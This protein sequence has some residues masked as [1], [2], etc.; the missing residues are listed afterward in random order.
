MIND[1]IRIVL[2]AVLGVGLVSYHLLTWCKV[3]F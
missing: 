3:L 1:D 2:I